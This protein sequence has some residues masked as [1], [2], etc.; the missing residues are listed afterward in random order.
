[1]LSRLSVF[2]VINPLTINL[3]RLF[4]LYLSTLLSF[5]FNR[6]SLLRSFPPF[7]DQPFAVISPFHDR[8]QTFAVISPFK[9]VMF[10][11]RALHGVMA[12]ISTPENRK[13]ALKRLIQ[14]LVS[15][16]SVI[17]VFPAS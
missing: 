5:L 2:P 7:H 14:L 4:R 6:F 10:P 9:K 13:C 8:D 17:N 11:G 1:M 3:L 16:R 12:S 15:G